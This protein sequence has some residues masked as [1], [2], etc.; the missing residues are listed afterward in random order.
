MQ[1]IVDTNHQK[2]RDSGPYIQLEV[3]NFDL[4]FFKNPSHIF[5][6]WVAIGANRGIIL[7]A[8]LLVDVDVLQPILVHLSHRGVY[9]LVCMRSLT[10]RLLYRALDSRIKQVSLMIT[11]PSSETFCPYQSWTIRVPTH[12]LQAL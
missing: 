6:G 5:F 8:G 12:P 7:L 2:M 11:R 4:N 3:S 9:R 1:M 10:N